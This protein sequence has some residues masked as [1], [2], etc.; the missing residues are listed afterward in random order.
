MNDNT[1]MISNVHDTEL[2]RVCPCCSKIVRPVTG[3]FTQC[4]VIKIVQDDEW[5][6]KCPECCH[7]WSVWARINIGN[8]IIEN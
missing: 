7:T 3:Y 5:Y 1:D 2:K 4:F 8:V 6:Y